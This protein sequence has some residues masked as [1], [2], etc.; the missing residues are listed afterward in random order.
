MLA[1]AAVFKNAVVIAGVSHASGANANDFVLATQ[2]LKSDNFPRFAD[3]QY[4]GVPGGRWTC[5]KRGLGYQPFQ[6][7]S[8]SLVD[9]NAQVSLLPYTI[10]YSTLDE[11]KEYSNSI[12]SMINKAGS[13]IAAD[14]NT[15]SYAAMEKGGDLD[16]H[17]NSPLID[18]LSH[19]A[20]PMTGYNYFC[21]RLHSHVGSCERRQAA[22]H[23]LYDFY[24]S[25]IVHDAA[26]HLGFAPVP[27]FIR[28][29]I[30]ERMISEVKCSN[31][32]HALAKYRVLETT[33][34]STA[35]FAPTVRVYM[36][37]YKTLD[38]HINWKLITEYHSSAIAASYKA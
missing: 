32:E 35:A 27:D 12:A 25:E 20:W 21:I 18:G 38:S 8:A 4:S 24:T 7:Y 26:I 34:Y 15:I 31:G 16:E 1:V 13:V 29:Y 11:A 17:L 22:M 6:Y 2:L 33:L 37:S 36:S 5:Y 10:G 19:Q 23:F 14:T 30:V 28:D 3:S 9:L